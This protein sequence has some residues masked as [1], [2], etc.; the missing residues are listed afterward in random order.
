MRNYDKEARAFNL[1]KFNAKHRMFKVYLDKK[2]DAALIE[3]LDQ[4]KNKSKAIRKIMKGA[5]INA[6]IVEEVSVIEF[7]EPLPLV[8][9]Q[10]IVKALSERPQGEIKKYKPLEPDYNVQCA[11]ENLKMAYWSNEPEKVAK[12]FTEAEDIIISAICHHGYTVCKQT[13]GE[14]IY[15]DK[16]DKKKGYGGYCSV[17]KCDMPIGINDWKQEYYESKFCPNCGAEMLKGSETK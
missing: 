15:T 3:H 4:Q 7:K 12:N 9:A 16:E 11:I 14:W 13:Q 5:V 6:P 8:K 1:A 10:K 17:C 2:E